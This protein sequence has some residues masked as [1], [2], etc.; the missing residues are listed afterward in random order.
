[1]V[2]GTFC[3]EVI[4]NIWDVWEQVQSP[5]LEK[6]LMPGLQ[7]QHSYGRGLPYYPKN[8]LLRSNCKSA[9]PVLPFPNPLPVEV[10]YVSFYSVLSWN[11]LPKLKCSKLLPAGHKAVVTYCAVGCTDS[12]T[13]TQ[14]IHHQG[15]PID[16][17]LNL[18][19]DIVLNGY[20]DI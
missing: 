20:L 15:C 3:S 10:G 7:N 16:T 6:P 11:F 4:Q 17:T 19:Q 13:P 14:E 5:L 9:C 2:W 12:P 18:L 8:C 1:M